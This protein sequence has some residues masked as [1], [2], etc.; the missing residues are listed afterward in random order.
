MKV[1]SMCFVC[2]LLCFVCCLLCFFFFLCTLFIA[3]TFVWLV[4]NVCFLICVW[5]YCCFFKILR[6]F[7]GYFV[8]AKKLQNSGL[9]IQ[10]GSERFSICKNCWPELAELTE[11][12]NEHRLK[13]EEKQDSTTRI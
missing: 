4:V 6:C 7:V 10:L 5:W 8:Y 12:W 11:D 3:Y 9:H 13:G 1:Y 2:C